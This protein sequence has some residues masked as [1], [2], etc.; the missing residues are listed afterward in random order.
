[1]LML[2]NQLASLL[3]YN[4]AVTNQRCKNSVDTLQR[5]IF[6]SA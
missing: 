4:F 5:G 2:I 3:K 1:M 6:L